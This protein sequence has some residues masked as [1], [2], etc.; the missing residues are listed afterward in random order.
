MKVATAARAKPI[1][2]RRGAAIAYMYGARLATPT[3]DGTL[4][5]PPVPTLTIASFVMREPL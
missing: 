4:N 3:S 2:K 5:I 1:G